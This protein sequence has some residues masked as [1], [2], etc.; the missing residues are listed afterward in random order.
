[1]GKAH[2]LFTSKIY[3]TLPLVPFAPFLGMEEGVQ[4]AISTMQPIS[5][6]GTL[7]MG[8]THVHAHT[9]LLIGTEKGE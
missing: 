6:Y 7:R 1:M 3:V 4:S 9:T 8:R 2:L 5:S